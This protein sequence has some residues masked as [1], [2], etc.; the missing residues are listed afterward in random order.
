MGHLSFDGSL[1]LIAL[2]GFTGTIGTSF[3]P[4]TYASASGA[5]S[6]VIQ[7]PDL[8]FDP[9]FGPTGLQTTLTQVGDDMLDPVAPVDPV[10]PGPEPTD[11][12]P[13]SSPTEARAIAK[14]LLESQGTS[15]EEVEASDEIT[16][17]ADEQDRN[18]EL[19]D[20]QLDRPEQR[21]TSQQGVG[22]RSI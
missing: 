3:T 9:V 2:D 8:G 4:I 5:F 16:E 6:N 1:E 15:L 12:P 19:C 22:C 11:P 18:E 17:L 10:D 20:E 13:P 7:P 14:N 21:T